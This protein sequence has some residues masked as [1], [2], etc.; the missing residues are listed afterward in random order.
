MNHRKGRALN[1]LLLLDKPSGITSNRAL[2][3][4]KKLFKAAKAGHTGS[5]DPLATGLLIICF[6]KTTKISQFLLIVHILVGST[7]G[8]RTMGKSPKL[9]QRSESSACGKCQNY[10]QFQDEFHPYPIWVIITSTKQK[11]LIHCRQLP[12]DSSLF[13]ASV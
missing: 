8:R 10:P 3:K 1:G 5:L 11:R 6:G 2:Q 12:P 13:T 4:V 7:Q 9:I